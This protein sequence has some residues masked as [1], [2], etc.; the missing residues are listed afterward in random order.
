MEAG[1]RRAAPPPR[2]REIARQRILCRPGGGTSEV[3][4]KPEKISRMWD[5]WL[6]F[7]DDTWYLF[8][9]CK[10][11]ADGQGPWFHGVALST[12]KDGVHWHEVGPV[13]SKDDGAVGIGT[14]AV[15]ESVGRAGRGRFIMN[16]STWFNASIC[17]Q[18]IRFA[19]SDDLVH[20]TRL[21][22]EA[23]FASDPA[24]YETWPE[25][26][27]ARWDCIYAIPRTEGGYYGYWTA[28]PRAFYPG[29]GFGESADGMRW[30]ALPPPVIEWGAVPPM[31]RLEVGAVEKIG[32]TY[33][34]IC[35]SW[36]TPYFGHLGGM[37]QFTAESPRGP[38]RP[39]RQNYDLLTSP[40]T[41]RMSYFARFFVSPHGMLVNHQ[42]ITKADEVYF[43]PL[44]AASVDAAGTLR[45]K[46]WQGNER[47]KGRGLPVSMADTGGASGMRFLA[48][49]LA[50]DPGVILEGIVQ[51]TGGACGIYVECGDGAG[52]AFLVDVGGG[53][54]IGGMVAGTGAFS[55]YD[56]VN[57]SLAA[58]TRYGFRL[59]LRHTMAE[60]YVDD[61]H[62]QCWSFA[63]EPTGR[64]ALLGTSSV[65]GADRVSA[66][67]MD[68]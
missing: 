19:E 50:L 33:Y 62:I 34:A 63:A 25:F 41:S 17:S 27:E 40:R 22:T 56:S 39:A 51:P 21:G 28:Y 58:R 8:Y 46:W 32:N 53:V 65:P 26:G 36:S 52:I 67:T 31:S 57:R 18:V 61:H 42:S 48:G 10:A 2:L 59:L 16:Y 3:I 13:L 29:F 11:P 14:G 20:W 15:W 30:V 35:G 49:T 6:Y 4:L 9:L 66:W 12:S 45:L 68:L 64:I 38:F 54:R 55:H 43:A 1:P 24:N 5:S 60:L 7:H 37:Y 23:E 44:K 47:L